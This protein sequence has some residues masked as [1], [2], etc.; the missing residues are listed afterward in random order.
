MC[1][2]QGEEDRL[3]FLQ[4]LYAQI[5]DNLG[6][7]RF[8]LLQTM[9]SHYRDMAADQGM[10]TLY[11]EAL[12]AL[13]P[14]STSKD[15]KD[16]MSYLAPHKYEEAYKRYLQDVKRIL[17]SRDFFFNKIKEIKNKR[18]ALERPDYKPDFY[19]VPK[20]FHFQLYGFQHK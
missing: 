15:M 7:D 16:L 14:R 5:P 11:H 2:Y 1:S 20:A 8:E 6:E 4:S 13:P 17:E 19:S 9:T 12:S 10:I 3:G 18:A